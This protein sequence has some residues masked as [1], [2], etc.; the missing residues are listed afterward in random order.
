MPLISLHRTLPAWVE[1]DPLRSRAVD[2]LGLQATSDRI[3]NEI[4]PGLSV[5]TTRARYYALLAWARRVCGAHPD[6][7]RIH[8]LEVALA[9]REA[10]LH[11]DNSRNGAERCRFVGINS[12]LGRFDAP[13]PD[14]RNAYRVPVWRAYRAS[15]R[16]LNLLDSNDELTDDGKALASRFVVACRPN[17]ASGKSMLPASACLSAMKSPEGALLEAALGVYKKGPPLK[18]DRSPAAKRAALERELRHLYDN[19]F[20]LAE[21][22]ATYEV[23]TGRE[24]PGT[25]CA[26]REAAVWERLSVGLNS[27]FLLWLHYIDRPSAAR[28]IIREP[29]RTRAVRSQPFA[30]I[31]INEEAA[32]HAIRSIRRALALRDR[33]AHHGGLSRC[34]PRAFELGEAVV[35]SATSVEDVLMRL[36][37]WHLAAKGDDAWLR[38][39]NY[40]KELARDADN[41]WKLPSVARLHSYRLGAFGQILTDLRQARWGR[42]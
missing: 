11:S 41:K 32:K 40:G 15:M 26:L 36:E 24:L 28:R 8:R 29:R 6:E 16:S 39:G 10:K 30:D 23:K 5:A 27:T 3:A 20:S 33:F 31:R 7:D 9:V 14:P 18:G 1:A 19:G 2:A 21:V 38:D 4:L 37:V 12:N 13:P 17:D 25:I 22:L 34:D 42:A 35:S